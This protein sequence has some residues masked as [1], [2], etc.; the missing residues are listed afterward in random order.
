MKKLIESIKNCKPMFFLLIE[1]TIC[2][3]LWIGLFKLIMV[4]I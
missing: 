1:I 3:A 2:I 4:M